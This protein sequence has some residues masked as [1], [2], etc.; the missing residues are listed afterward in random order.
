MNYQFKNEAMKTETRNVTN[1]IAGVIQKNAA[2]FDCEII[3]LGLTGRDTVRISVKG[4]P[5]NL[6]ALFEYAYESEE[7]A[8]L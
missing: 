6:E 4:T 5:E 3:E 2:Q 7:P 1:H 8:T